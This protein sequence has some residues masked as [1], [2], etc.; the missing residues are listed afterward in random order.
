[1]RIRTIKPEFFKD[2]ELAEL[3]PEARLFFIGLWCA[4]D[5]NGNIE[6]RP[7]RLKIEILP[8]CGS[9]VSQLCLGLEQG[10][11]VAKY[12][13]DGQQY[14]SIR[15]WTKHQR[16][17]GKE[18]QSGGRYPL[19]PNDLHSKTQQGHTR[20]T[21]EKQPESQ[22][23]GTG[24]REGKG[25]GKGTG[26][27]VSDTNVSSC[28]KNSDILP[29]LWE[30]SPPKARSRSS[31]KQVHSE[32]GK[33]KAKDRP[34][35]DE[36]LHALEVWKKCDEWRKENGEFIPGLHRWINC[37]QWENLPVVED[38]KSTIPKPPTEPTGWREAMKEL[39]PEA[40]DSLAWPQIPAEVRSEITAHL[41][42]K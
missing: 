1:M 29:K 26:K 8:Y 35:E 23:Q 11:W 4:A 3:S 41:D 25:T 30:A 6:W 34:T 38:F 32:W 9:D 16:I 10:G 28:P 14:L 7:K 39:Y 5:A 20:D 13:I 42:K 17:N 19:P 2:E 40:D 31:K 33:I 22:E 36:I 18:G 15:N 12:T 21:P 27:G 24:N 37:R